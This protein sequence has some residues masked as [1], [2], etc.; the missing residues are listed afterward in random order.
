VCIHFDARRGV[1]SPFAL[2]RRVIYSQRRPV[3]EVPELPK[4]S[5]KVANGTGLAKHRGWAYEDEFRLLS[6][7]D[8]LNGFLRRQ[9]RFATFDS[10][11]LVGLT[12]G[13]NMPEECQQEL[14]AIASAHTPLIPVWR[15]RIHARRFQLT[16][17]PVTLGTG[18][19]FPL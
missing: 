10:R 13:A 19:A 14:I 12:L 3:F 1:R 5:F 8:S 18:P 6:N 2:A 9:G 17:E 11:C 7:P 16:F 4:D 15:A